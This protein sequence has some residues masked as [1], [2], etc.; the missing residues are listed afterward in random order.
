[1]K[2]DKD[3]TE[4]SK[5]KTVGIPEG[6][7]IFEQKQLWVK[8]FERLGCQVVCSGHTTKSIM[9]SGIELC[10]N[11]TC[12]PVKVFTG[13]AASLCE[14]VD[15]IFIPRY[16][17]VCPHE[18]SCPKFCG[19]PDE[20]RISLK[21]KMKILEIDIDFNRDPKK[22]YKSLDHFAGELGLPL[23]AVENAFNRI[24]ECGLA[25]E[26]SPN[27]S[28]SCKQALPV[29]AVLGHPYMI[30]DRLLS[31]NL[32][33]KLQA[34]GYRVMTPYDVKRSVRRQKGSP[35]LSNS[36]FETGLDILG[37]AQALVNLPELVGMVYLS[38]FA[39]GID[40]LVMEIIEHKIRNGRQIPFLKIT[41]DEHSGETGF[42]T[43]LEAFL[44][45]LPTNEGIRREKIV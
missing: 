28:K 17:S 40:S 43:R 37:G 38:P 25:A 11:E 44:D 4:L 6:L 31:M 24:V 27:I 19:L 8:F 3:V 22:T 20:V 33:G 41:V 34:A 26:V 16:A 36:F 5:I 29:I 39:C 7:M 42:D 23:K 15:Y 32:I 35:F 18:K 14:K 10:C 30:F 2:F 45:M 1:M 13:H 9:N 12:L 21:N